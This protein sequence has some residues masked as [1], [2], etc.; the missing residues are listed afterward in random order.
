MLTPFLVKPPTKESLYLTIEKTYDPKYKPYA[1]IFPLS[2]ISPLA[3]DRVKNKPSI[4]GYYRQC[5]YKVVKSST[6][7]YNT[8]ETKMVAS[9]NYPTIANEKS[10]LQLIEIVEGHKTLGRNQTLVDPVSKNPKLGI[11]YCGRQTPGA[12][13]IAQ[14]LLEF[15]K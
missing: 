8:Q 13:N 4:P 10:A 3:M 11:I 6:L 12:H 15:T 7:D 14:G 1:R 5:N 9:L 2:N